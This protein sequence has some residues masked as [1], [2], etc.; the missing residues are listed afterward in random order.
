MS[1]NCFKNINDGTKIK[2]SLL[3]LIIIIIIIIIIILSNNNEMIKN[4]NKKII[5]TIIIIIIINII[6]Q[7]CLEPEGNNLDKTTQFGNSVNV[8]D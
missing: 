1:S 2:W 4:K 5:I 7:N 3:V 6:K 8:S